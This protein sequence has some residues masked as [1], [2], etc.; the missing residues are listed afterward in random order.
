ME[1]YLKPELKSELREIS[2]LAL[3]SIGDAVFD[4][5]VRTYLCESG[6]WAADKLHSRTVEYVSAKAQA[7][8]AQALLSVLTD[9]ETQMYKRGRNSNTGHTPKSS[10]HKEYHTAT[11]VETV[12]GY[13]YLSGNTKRLNELFE[14]MIR[15]D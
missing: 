6:I 14:I 9:E 7:K 13:L 15:K 1:D 11:A 10:T 4:L 5:M 3:A 8:A 2:T 12:F